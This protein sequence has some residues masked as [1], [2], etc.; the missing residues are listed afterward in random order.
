V[1]IHIYGIY[2]YVDIYIC[3]ENIQTGLFYHSYENL[4]K[5]ECSTLQI[6]SVSEV[7]VE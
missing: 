3:M 4:F 1:C 7:E 6:C 2:V 5:S